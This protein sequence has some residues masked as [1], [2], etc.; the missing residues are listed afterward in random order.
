M[1]QTHRVI[2]V[3]NCSTGNS[4]GGVVYSPI[5]VSQTITAGTHGYGMGNV[6]VLGS[7]LRNCFIGDDTICPTLTEAMGM[8]MDKYQ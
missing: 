7:A 6:I 5:G 2:K 8:G 1:K 4:E 3:G